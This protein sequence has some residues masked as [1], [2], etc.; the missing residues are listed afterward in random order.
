MNEQ[1]SF[2][3]RPLPWIIIAAIGAVGLGGLL[4][5]GFIEGRGEATAEAQREQPVKAAVEVSRSNTGA[6]IITLS[7]DLQRQADIQLKQPNAASYQQ[8][9][10]AY[11]SVLDLQPFTDLGNTIANAKA[12][13]AIAEAKLVASQA[14][15]QRAQ[16]LHKDGQN[17]STAQLQAAE[18]TYQSDAASVRAAQVQTQNAA[19]SAYQ[20]WGPIL[21][22]SL[23]DGT[24]LATDLVQHK[25][26][27]IQVTLPL[28]VLLSEAPQTAFIDITTGQRVRIEFVSPATRTDPKIQ[29][30]S[31]FYTADAASGA[32]PDMNVIALLPAGQPTP[33][34]AIPASAV[35]WLQGRAWVYLQSAANT[36][37]RREIP[38]TQPAPGGGYV[39]PALPDDP[40][41]EADASSSY[42][43]AQGFPMNDALVVKGAQVLLS[44]EFSAQIQVGGD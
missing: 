27:L 44:Q 11:G 42:G 19:A 25:R 18:A 21:G 40:R 2:R 20:A 34:I 26:V 29:G 12:Q 17:I 32:L 36:F 5:W 13:L 31:F 3:A 16:V 37:T 6:P 1:H 8:Q 24:T 14:A 41:P 39:V 7:P 38:T 22:Q 33:G 10:Q 4:I 43:A 35:V 15:F 9:M 28:G 23:I 30:V